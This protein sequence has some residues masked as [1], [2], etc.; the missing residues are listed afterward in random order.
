[1][2]GRS[3]SKPGEVLVALTNNDTIRGPACVHL[4]TDDRVYVCDNDN[5]QILVLASLDSSTPGVLL[6]CI[7]GTMISPPFDYNANGL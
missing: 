5:N 2:R 1:M 3:S 6:L 7:T 4:D